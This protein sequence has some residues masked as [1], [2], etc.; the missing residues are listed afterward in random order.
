MTSAHMA[1]PVSD[2][3]PGAPA[4]SATTSPG[5]NPLLRGIIGG[6]V[7]AAVVFTLTWFAANYAA[8]EQNA[9]G[10]VVVPPFHASSHI[11]LLLITLYIIGGILTTAAGPVAE[12][13]R[14]PSLPWQLLTL[15]TAGIA[16]GVLIA[17]PERHLAE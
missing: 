17:L 2:P 11:P 15:A 7:A 12:R 1:L 16:L 10:Q 4:G 13:K 8:R 3:Q 6:V 5:Q 14:R 9:Q